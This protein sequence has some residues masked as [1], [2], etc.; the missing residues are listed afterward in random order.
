MDK[1]KKR[2][3]FIDLYR[4]WAI[5]LMIETHIF[6]ALLSP[7]LK[8]TYGFKVLS[9]INGLVAP[10]FLFISGFAFAVASLRKIDQYRSYGFEFWRQLWRILLI[11]IIGYSLGLP[12]LSLHK[13]LYKA[14]PQELLPF[15]RVDVLQCIAV[16]LLFMFLLRIYIKSDKIYHYILIGV[17]VVLFMAAPAINKIDFAQ[18]MPVYLANYINDMY[19]SL[20]PVFPWLAFMLPG[21]TLGHYYLKLKQEG[22]EEEL[23]NKLLLYSII[24]FVISAVVLWSHLEIFAYLSSIKPGQFFYAMRLAIVIMLLVIA[25]I[26]EIRRQTEKSFVIDIGR[27]SL[28]IYWLH[29]QVIYRVIW[30]GI[31]LNRYVHG[32]FGVWECVVATILLI[33]LM[34]ICAYAWGQL[35]MRFLK[36]IQYATLGLIGTLVIMFLI[37]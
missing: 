37:K 16:G 9:F 29:L 18:Y 27:E 20:F 3:A 33:L 10:S 17:S 13:L 6:N 14:T 12:Y 8:A 23:L 30:G 26:Y 28:L 11:I 35:K 2:L 24:V 19:G 34:A 5:L 4:G 1:A 21:A 25:R 32:T 31:S 15:L 22:R 7:A 36:P